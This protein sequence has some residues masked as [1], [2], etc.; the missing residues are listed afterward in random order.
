MNKIYLSIILFSAVITKEKAMS[1]AKH[2]SKGNQR[3][4]IPPDGGWGWMVFLGVTMVN[5]SFITTHFLIFFF[6][7]LHFFC[8]L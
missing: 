6:I 8:V 1:L 4:L 7:V 3:K 2:E 5:V